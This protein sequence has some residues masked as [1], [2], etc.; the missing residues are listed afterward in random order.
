MPHST[1][2][3]FSLEL[4]RQQTEEVLLVSPV[5]LQPFTY[6]V[7]AQSAGIHPYFGSKKQLI[8]PVAQHADDYTLRTI[9]TDDNTS[10][11]VLGHKESLDSIT[12]IETKN[13]NN[14]TVLLIIKIKNVQPSQNPLEVWVMDEYRHV[15]IH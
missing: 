9:L 5:A 8:L 4:I 6:V 2:D 10:V 15:Y 1:V 3:G 12:L 14:R 11:L 7:R 13:K